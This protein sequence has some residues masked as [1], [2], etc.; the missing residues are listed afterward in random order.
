METKRKV[1]I[2]D[3][4]FAHDVFTSPYQQS[5]FM[6]WERNIFDFSNDEPIFF[7]N[8][9]LTLA[10]GKHNMNI[11][12]ILEPPVI[13]PNTYELAPKLLSNFN[14][15]LT[16]EKNLLESNSKFHFFPHGGCW[17]KPEDR[18]IY[19][20]TKL[21]SI[22]SSEKNHAPGHRL[23]H[24]LISKWKNGMEIFGRGYNPIPY[25]LPALQD[26]M[27]SFVIENCKIDYYFTEKLIDCLVTGTIPIYFGCPSIN[28]FF[29]PEGFIFLESEEDLPHI[30]PQITAETYEK[31]LRA[32]EE[33]FQKALEYILIEDWIFQNT[34]I[35]NLK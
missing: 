29:N 18:R 13:E 8:H 21:V 5:K 35:F 11:G 27:F 2:V 15:I 34:D 16:Y 32:V 19:P 3:F 10:N 23:R 4:A 20:K 1:K 12:L 6:V 14:R 25:K 28:K 24:R 17:I 9:S 31:K 7:A 26:F 22:V 33:N 30:I